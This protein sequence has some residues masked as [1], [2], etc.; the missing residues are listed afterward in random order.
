MLENHGIVISSEYR[1]TALNTQSSLKLI[2]VEIQ[3][4]YDKIAI[5]AFRHLHIVCRPFAVIH[6]LDDAV[7]HLNKDLPIRGLNLGGYNIHIA[8]QFLRE[9]LQRRKT[10][11]QNK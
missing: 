7:L 9:G 6:K 4:F 5:N 11:E 3:N 8:I 10:Q 2:Y 1:S